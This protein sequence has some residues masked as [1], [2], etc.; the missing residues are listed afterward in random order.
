MRRMWQSFTDFLGPTRLWILFGLLATTG[1]LSLILNVAE[2]EGVT[3]VQTGLVL[4]FMAGAFII[5]FSALSPYQ[6]GRWLGIL[7]PSFVLFALGTVAFP[8]QR[9]LLYG[10]A[11]GWV[12]AAQFVFRPREPMA[13]QKAVKALRKNDIPTALAEIDAL[14][15][16]S[17]NSPEHYHFRARLYRLVGKVKEA[18][19]DYK[20][21]L[22]IAPTSPVG[23]N[24]LAEL[25]LQAGQ[26]T[27]ARAAALK[28]FELTDG[29]W[30]TAYNL[31]MIEDRM[32]ESESALSHLDHALSRKVSD[33][34]HR[35]LIQ[36]Y[37]ARALARLGR[38]NE[39]AQ[40]VELMRADQK[41]VAQWKKLLEDGQAEVL[42]A[43]L[44]AD[45]ETA[46]A[47]LTGKLTVAA[48]A[49]KE[50]TK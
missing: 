9:G 14:I 23:H 5:I 2:G 36:L 32:A 30:V 25:E 29:D 22:E 13:Y 19:R 20:K 49:A 3:A 41:A 16:Q 18:R 4:V 1:L 21:V 27:A 28:A 45:V 44:G 8:D 6:R 35:L 10:L 33:A 47:L 42:R 50:V 40:A 38:A 46:E 26:Y 12:I 39:A 48:L 34:R 37:R 11:F 7:T 17:P 31:G 15:K 43:V 24:E